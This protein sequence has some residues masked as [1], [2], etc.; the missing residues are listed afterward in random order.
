[1]QTIRL[2]PVE[3][4]YATHDL[5]MVHGAEPFFRVGIQPQ[6]DRPGS[7]RKFRTYIRFDLSTIPAGEIVQAQL[8]LTEVLREEIVGG[9]VKV[10]ANRLIGIGDPA[11]CEWQEELLDDTNLSHWRNQEE[12]T[13]K[14]A[15]VGN[16]WFFDMTTIV[17]EWLTGNPTRLSRICATCDE[18]PIECG[19]SPMSCISQ[20]GVHHFCT[21]PCMYG[22]CPAGT[23]CQ[24]VRL[25]GRPWEL[26]LNPD[27]AQELCPAGF[28]PLGGTLEASC[29]LILN[30]PDFGSAEVPIERSVYFSSKEGEAPPE[31]QVTVELP[32][33]P[34]EE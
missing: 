34:A 15:E 20:D 5:R 32:A 4:T 6:A 9:P 21:Q 13:F 10:A 23:T 30:D 31:L 27:A 14:G 3:D 2:Q 7:F 26:C 28:A 8:L 11:V 22:R 25:E 16:Q 17:R 33:P 1:L 29:G 12:F 18:D 19:G 24:E